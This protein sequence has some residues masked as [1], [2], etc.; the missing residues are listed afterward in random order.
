MLQLLRDPDTLDRTS[1][2]IFDTRQYS[3][4]Q[5]LP[6]IFTS[7][8]SCIAVNDVEGYLMAGSSDGDI[9]VKVKALATWLRPGQLGYI[10]GVHSFSPV[11]PPSFFPSTAV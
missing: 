8:V 7:A 3:L 4:L 2:G 6:G 9:K 10:Y 11:L 1:P 5:F